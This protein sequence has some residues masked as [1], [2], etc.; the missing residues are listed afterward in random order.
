MRILVIPDVHLKPWIFDEADKIAKKHQID[1]FAFVGDLVDDFGQST[2]I[3]LYNKTFDMAEQFIRNHPNIVWCW[4]NHDASYMWNRME[5]GF[6]FF[7][8]DTV[9]KRNRQLKELLGNRAGFVRRVDKLLFSHAGLMH[10]FIERIFPPNTPIDVIIKDIDGFNSIFMWE[11]DSPIWARPQ[12]DVWCKP[13]DFGLLQVVGHTPV[14]SNGM[15][16]G[17]LSVD[18]FSTYQDGKPIGTQNFVIIDSE[19]CK[20]KEASIKK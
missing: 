9:V 11:D 19:T 1:S 17:V 14:A 18:S 4:G 15:N 16:G 2:N 5:T 20:Y 3:R 12:Y 13:H 8:Q 6:S 7:A 10:S